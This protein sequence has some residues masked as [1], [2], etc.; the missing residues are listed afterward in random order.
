MGTNLYVGNL[1]FDTTSADL[2]EMFSRVGHVVEA[3][4][5]IDRKINRSKGF[6]FVTMETDEEAQKAIAEFDGKEVAGRVVKVNEAKP[7]EERADGHSCAASEREDNPSGRR[8]AGSAPRLA[9]DYS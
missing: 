2:N 4:V 3:A 9:A 8:V 6:G 1:S 5:I 7:R